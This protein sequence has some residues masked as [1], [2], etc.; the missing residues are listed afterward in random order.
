VEERH[1]E[2]TKTPYSL[3]MNLITT[4]LSIGTQLSIGVN[5]RVVNRFPYD[6]SRVGRTT[7]RCVFLR[8]ARNLSLVF[9]VFTY[10]FNTFSSTIIMRKKGKTEVGGEIG[11]EVK[12][13]PE[14]IRPYLSGILFYSTF[15]ENATAQ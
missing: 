1:E 4:R 5:K 15:K 9:D 10:L 11:E 13:N 3:N 2:K 14:Q 6:T 8:H 12:K 7:S